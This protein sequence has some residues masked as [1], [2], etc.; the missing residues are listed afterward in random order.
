MDP[1]RIQRI[2]ANG[3]QWT[4]IPNSTWVSLLMEDSPR[5]VRIAFLGALGEHKCLG[6]YVSL[7]A[8]LNQ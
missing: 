6:I 1:K 7:E 3:S 5:A 2:P 8:A 4:F